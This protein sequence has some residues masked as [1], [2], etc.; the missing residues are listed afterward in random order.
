MKS[1]CLS[2]PR[3]LHCC[4]LSQSEHCCIWAMPNMAWAWLSSTNQCLRVAATVIGFIYQVETSC[5]T[6]GPFLNDLPRWIHMKS[7]SVDSC[8]IY[9]QVWRPAMDNIS[10]LINILDM[11]QPTILVNNFYSIQMAMDLAIVVCDFSWV[12]TLSSKLQIKKM[13]INVLFNSTL[14]W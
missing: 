3:A 9:E 12:I 2:E 6:L 7:V 10:A 5:L 8:E 4:T 13:C 11:E 1:T 14:Q